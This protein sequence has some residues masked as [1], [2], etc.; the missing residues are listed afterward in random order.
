ML[1]CRILFLR[2]TSAWERF[3]RDT[4][5]G[6]SGALAKSK[7][8]QRGW[9]A[10][11]LNPSFASFLANDGLSFLLFDTPF[12]LLLVSTDIIACAQ[13]TGITAKVGQEFNTHDGRRIHTCIDSW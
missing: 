3:D 13:R 6:Y 11:R 9:A 7:R 1:S 10:C 5:A 2:F 4:N 8:A 12:L